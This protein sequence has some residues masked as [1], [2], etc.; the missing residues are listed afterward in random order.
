[1]PPANIDLEIPTQLIKL[2]HFNLLSV[3]LGA[4]KLRSLILLILFLFGLTPLLL[5]VFMNVPLVMDRMES[6]YHKAYLQNLRADFRDLDQHLA[7]RND[8]LRLLSKIPE[9]ALLIGSGMP[10]EAAKIR[11]VQWV[12][13]MLKDQRDITRIGFLDTN[14]TE[15]FHLS[16]DPQTG[17]MET[18]IEPLLL[19]AQALFD[20]AMQA[21]SGGVLISRLIINPDALKD[22]PSKFMMLRLIG[23]VFSPYQKGPNGEEPLT[24]AVIIDIDVG[25][26]ANA[27][28]D[29]LWVHDD[30]RYLEVT[31]K[32]RDLDANGVANHNAF[33]DFHGLREIFA[34]NELALWDKNDKQVIWIPLFITETGT[35]LWAGRA[36]DS[37][38]IVAFRKTVTTSFILIILGLL[39]MVLFA[40]RWFA[41]RTE[42]FS[43][44]LINGISQVLKDNKEISFNWSGAKELRELGDNLT[45]L[46]HAHA[47]HTQK[48][49]RH[50][51]DLEESNRY[52]S[53]FLANVS[54]E[55]RTPL[56][57]IL[58]LSKMLAST[59]NQLN[60]EERKQAQVINNAGE[61]LHALI[62]NILDLSRIEAG[63][64]TFSLEQVDLRETLRNLMEMI[65][66]I[67]NDKQLPLL[68][69]ID[70]DAPLKVFSDSE[71]IRQILKNF[72]SNAIKFTK[73]GQVTL[74]LSANTQA[75][76]EHCPI[77]L[78]VS[79]TGTGIPK[80]KQ[81]AIFEAFQ[82]ADG[83]TNR[84]YGGTGLGLTI[85]RSLADMLGGRIELESKENQG[86]TFS[87]LLPEKFD[88]SEL[89][90]DLVSYVDHN[91]EAPLFITT[92]P[93]PQEAVTKAPAADY[94]AKR[95]ILIDDDIQNLLSLT[96]TLEQW[97]LHVTAA[98]DGHEALETLDED[99]DFDLILLDIM[100]PDMDGYEILRVL[101]EDPRYS[102]IPVLI[103]TATT[104]EN[105]E[106]HCLQAGANGYLSKPIET[107]VL[108]QALDTHLTS[109]G[110]Q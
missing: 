24:G 50:A 26:L 42:R 100:M 34:K 110:P 7:S 2:R 95:V 93:S 109:P 76:A 92:E 1:M 47:Q 18:P 14:N 53:Q 98:G 28:Q 86:S 75:G 60:E 57:S 39:I 69:S 5:A 67:A 32:G 6:F 59:H 73:S 52:K 66:P 90:E 58:L 74:R 97:N 19:P 29:T 23:P 10:Q 38:P 40:A 17:L 48:L 54:H 102:D 36:V 81:A 64:C 70:D 9:A 51:H 45:E 71:K 84:R 91:D 103:L 89:A 56:N 65:S 82:Q 41:G 3:K 72:L 94:Q 33:N 99:P 85:S 96:P 107:D 61:D 37:S 8:T 77:R 4:M 13:R 62:N 46:A 44:E 15:R 31:P 22:D 88:S 49:Q 105:D 35:H 78:A 55:L 87:L 12:N 63:K 27:Y 21:N 30:G 106:A 68:L 20:A 11:F 25:G 79:D 108:K 83:S 104:K 80:D 101:R 43:S 16:R